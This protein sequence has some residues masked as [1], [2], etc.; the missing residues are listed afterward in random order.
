[1]SRGSRHTL[2]PSFAGSNCCS[3]IRPGL[4]P[5]HWTPALY[6]MEDGGLKRLEESSHLSPHWL[7]RKGWSKTQQKQLCGSRKD[8]TDE[9]HLS[10]GHRSF[11]QAWWEIASHLHT[12]RVARI[13][14]TGLLATRSTDVNFWKILQTMFYNSTKVAQS[15]FLCSVWA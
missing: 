9:G 5:F 7:L 4:S 8:K 14:D 11:D 2:A 15:W 13:V 12:D 6:G 10:T 1:M 3:W